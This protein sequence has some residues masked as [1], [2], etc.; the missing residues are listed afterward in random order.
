LGLDAIEFKKEDTMDVEKQSFGLKL[1]ARF[2]H[3]KPSS[4]PFLSAICQQTG[5]LMLGD[6][7]LLY[8]DGTLEIPTN[9]DADLLEEFI[10]AITN[11]FFGEVV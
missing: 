11:K 8:P 9:F 3:S 2:L 10:E 7:Y 4:I 6:D 5:T 1:L